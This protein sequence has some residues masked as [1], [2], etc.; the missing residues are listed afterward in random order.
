MLF[1]TLELSGGDAQMTRC[2]QEITTVWFWCDAYRK[3]DM[4]SLLAMTYTRAVG[5]R[6]RMRKWL[7]PAML[8]GALLWF[9]TRT[10]SGTADIDVTVELGPTVA[11]ADAV[12]LELARPDGDVVGQFVRT[13][14]SESTVVRFSI[15]VQTG[16]YV[17]VAE[18][19]R[20]P[21]RMRARRR[22]HVSESAEVKVDLSGQWK[23]GRA[24]P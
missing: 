12:R 23:R 16:T 7:A 1:H 3:L 2:V 9:G 8:L 5:V 10:C 15:K 22:I 4:A 24:A 14:T 11:D 6:E 17:L 21:H 13:V 18:L 19:D 20:S